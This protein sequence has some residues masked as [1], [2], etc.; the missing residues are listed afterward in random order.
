[1][2]LFCRIILDSTR[3]AVARGGR[4]VRQTFRS[5]RTRNYRLYFA[6][7]SISVTGE[8]M[9]RIGQAWLVLELTDSATLLGL[10]AGLQQLPTLLLGVW[11]G[12]L[13]DRLDKRTLLLWSQ[14]LAGT[15]S[16]IL[17]VLV[18]TGAVQLWMV[19]VLAFA[20]GSTTALE[21]PAKHT[22]VTEMV[23]S[24]DVAN[25]VTLNSIVFNAAKAVGPAIAGIM[26][27]TVG[28][29]SAFFANAVSYLGALVAL[30]LMRRA[31][32][33]PA[34]ITARARGQVREG[35][36]Y[37]RRTPVL[38]GAVVLM[39]VS[40]T[41]AYEWA[42]TLPL[43]A[44]DAFG[45]DAQ[46]YG[47][48]FSAM[49]IGAVL[50]G[51]VVAS[52]LQATVRTLVVTALVF[53]TLMF[54]TAGA[55][56]LVLALAALT[57]LGGAS[58]AFRSTATALLQLEA[59]PALRGRVMSILTVA[60]AGSTPI[61][62]PLAGW[63]AEVAGPRAAFA[64]G[65]GATIVAALWMARYARR[66]GRVRSGDPVDGSDRDVLPTAAYPARADT[67]V[68]DIGTSGL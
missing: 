50:G 54:V 63:I 36:R 13:A 38:A 65:G 59:A 67:R 49:G 32:L 5:L 58:I 26:I 7:H 12:L 46:T 47:L 18:V 51:L 19:L 34:S 28:L 17:A 60:M 20:L 9:Q 44:R 30:S 48:M 57:A 62:G 40:G 14:A 43:L 2:Y 56:T 25:A 68:D 3:C 16:L 11:G 1:M 66:S 31:E 37:V 35:F 15:F 64:L 4:R 45:G 8:W 21:R 33:Y 24:E 22:F 61:G 41:L 6:G 39:A 23:P 53:G 42:V 55:P 52:S 27:A 10:T 29:S